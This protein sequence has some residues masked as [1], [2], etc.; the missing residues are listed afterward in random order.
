ML[1]HHDDLRRDIGTLTTSRLIGAAPHYLARV[2]QHQSLVV[3]WAADPR[4]P[5][6]VSI[7]LDPSPDGRGAVTLHC[8]HGSISE[9]RPLQMRHDSALRLT[10][11][12]GDDDATHDSD[13]APALALSIDLIPLV[14]PGPAI[15]TRVT[16]SVHFV[17]EPWWPRDLTDALRDL[18]DLW[19]RRLEAQAQAQARNRRTYRERLDNPDRPIAVLAP[20]AATPSV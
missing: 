10:A 13:E 2:L 6:A 16:L 1:F 5:P 7:G 19:L 14:Q 11:K 15:A 3:P 8:P 18:A 20:I 17:P 12:T 9:R 4:Q